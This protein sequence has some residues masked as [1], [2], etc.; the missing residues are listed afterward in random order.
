METFSEAT[1][2]G[3]WLRAAEALC[4]AKERIYNLV[5]EIQQ[6]GLATPTS[7]QIEARVNRFLLDQKCQPIHTV[8][9]TIFPATEYRM[10]GIA[11]VYRYPEA[12]YPF[13]RGIQANS[14]GT[15][16]LRMLERKCSDGTT[17]RP[18]EYAI[19]KL[20]KQLKKAGPLR[21]VY[22]FDLN[23][24]ALELK[25]YDPEIDHTNVRGGQCLSHISLK[26]GV[27]RELY[28]TAL[29]RYQY[30]IQKALGNFL[31]L[32]RLQ[33]CIAR[34]LEIPVGPLVSHATL[35]VLESKEFDAP[36][37]AQLA[38]DLVAD[39]RAIADRGE[40]REAA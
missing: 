18:L 12:V 4:T 34:E 37:S 17:F 5:L 28:L 9:E 23:T 32:A 10:G 21:A 36:W 25:T 40:A 38:K 2:A 3:I 33:A 6:P 19:G 31:G 1:R 24:E 27:E 13:I 8:A 35:A 26:L 11:A 7:K 22:E 14:K 16:A 29:F 20:K 15:Y 39:C 30:F